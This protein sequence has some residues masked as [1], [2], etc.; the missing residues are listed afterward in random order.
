MELQTN[1]IHK[2]FPSN[3]K[4]KKIK[5][6]SSCLEFNE[7]PSKE[8]L[9]KKNRVT[10]EYK[11]TKEKFHIRKVETT[12]LGLGQKQKIFNQIIHGRLISRRR[13]KRAKRK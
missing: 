13:R 8:K 2:K 4:D 1:K 5:T 11:K 6:F 9:K 10:Q 12:E 3:M 7:N